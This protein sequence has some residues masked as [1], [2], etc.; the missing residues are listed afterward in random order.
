MGIGSRSGKALTKVLAVAALFCFA[1]VLSA[2]A[3]TVVSGTFSGIPPNNQASCVGG[4]GTLTISSTAA[5]LGGVNFLGNSFCFFGG[6]APFSTSSFASFQNFGG[7]NNTLTAAQL[8][9]LTPGVYFEV[10]E[11]CNANGS[12]NPFGTGFKVTITASSITLDNTISGA[13]I[14]VS[15]ANVTRTPEPSS[16]LLLGSGLLG[17]VGTGIFRKRLVA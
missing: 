17:L 6:N 5:T 8:L 16:L 12:C 3:D 15:L 4:S 9:A 10:G 2:K 1:A 13:S 14:A 7:N 11:E